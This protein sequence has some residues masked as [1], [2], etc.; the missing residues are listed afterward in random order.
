MKDFISSHAANL[1]VGGIKSSRVE[2]YYPP[3]PPH[4]AAPQICAGTITAYCQLGQTTFFN[5]S[6]LYVSEYSWGKKP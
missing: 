6:K 3:H 4:P 1:A 2:T 5:L